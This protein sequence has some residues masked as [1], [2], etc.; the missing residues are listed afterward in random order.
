MTSPKADALLDA[1]EVEFASAG[2]ETAS[3]CRIMREAGTDPGAV[4]YHSGGREALAAA[5]ALIR[6]DVET[7]HVLNAPSAGRLTTRTFR[8]P[9]ITFFS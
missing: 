1:A 2:I 4:R 9:P 8:S 7:A 3:L 6:S 5:D